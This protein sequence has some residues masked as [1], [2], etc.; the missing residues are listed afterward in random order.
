MTVKI[1]HIYN[2]QWSLNEDIVSH[3]L[4]G[5]LLGEKKKTHCSNLLNKY[6][7]IIVIIH[8]ERNY[9]EEIYI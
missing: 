2:M 9:Y 8:K 5:P 4:R 6:Q 3:E 1:L 7:S